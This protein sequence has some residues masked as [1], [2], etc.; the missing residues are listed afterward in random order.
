MFSGYYRKT[1]ARYG[2]GQRTELWRLLSWCVGD[3]HADRLC[4]LL[5][6]YCR[7]FG[8]DVER[9]WTARRIK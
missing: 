5:D 9:F 1:T 7:V 2:M 3:A 4:W 8:I 6:L